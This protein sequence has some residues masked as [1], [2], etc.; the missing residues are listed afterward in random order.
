MTKRRRALAPV[1][2][3]RREAT[4][5]AI[6]LAGRREPERGE[7]IHRAVPMPATPPRERLERRDRTPVARARASTP[8]VRVRTRIPE[9]P[10]TRVP[11]TAARQG[12]GTAALRASL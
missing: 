8:G 6:F 11:G 1:A 9:A 7:A 2:V 12:R 4:H 3:V 5:P 10:A